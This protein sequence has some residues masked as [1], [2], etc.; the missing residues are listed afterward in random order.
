MGTANPDIQ[1]LLLDGP[2]LS[3]IA[4]GAVGIIA[5]VLVEFGALSSHM[6]I[7]IATMNI[8]APLLAATMAARGFFRNSGAR[9]APL[10]IATLLQMAL[11]WAAHGPA[12]Q[13]AGHSSPAIGLVLHALLLL[14]ATAFWCAIIVSVA[15]PWQA[16][17]ALL[18][19]GKLSCLLGALLVFSPRLLIHAPVQTDTHASMHVSMADQ[20]LAGL[21]MLAACPLSYILAAIVITSQE[22][23]RLTRS[24]SPDCQNPSRVGG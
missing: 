22:I 12:V 7:H 23:T 16:I 2:T 8:A 9:S 18:V 3:A 6:A 15:R 11:L 5:V 10:W 1:R 13:Q 20:H 17:L 14:V 4:V 19:S 21:L 24:H